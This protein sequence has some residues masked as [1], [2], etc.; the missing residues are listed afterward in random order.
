MIEL[1][2]LFIGNVSMGSNHVFSMACRIRAW[3]GHWTCSFP[4]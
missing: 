3:S 1:S 4:G 2:R